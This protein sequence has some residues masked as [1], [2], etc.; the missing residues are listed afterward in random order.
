[1]NKLLW[2]CLAS[3]A[4]AAI[5]YGAN[6]Q[7]FPI[8]PI[9]I[10]VSFAPG[11][12]NDIVVRHISPELTELL[13]TQVVIENR[14]GVNGAIGTEAVARAAPEGYTLVQA[15]VSNLILN[16]LLDTKVAYNTLRDVAGL[17]TIGVTHQV[18][19]L[20]PSAPARSLPERVALANQQ[21]G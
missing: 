1:M 4:S 5:T 6:A 13:K 9:R 14:P 18:I 16:P 11:G 10:I 17:S 20:H 7:D 2:P 19:A 8:K 21:L 15:G 3:A 12:S